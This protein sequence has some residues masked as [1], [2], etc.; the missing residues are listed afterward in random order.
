MVATETSTL[1]H[2]TLFPIS[3]VGSGRLEV[4]RKRFG[5]G[6]GGIRRRIALGGSEGPTR[7]GE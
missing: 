6:T 3:N 1:F 4:L 5:I 7:V 2:G